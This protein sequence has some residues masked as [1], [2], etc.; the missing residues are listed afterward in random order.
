MR[1][2]SQFWIDPWGKIH[3]WKG[4]KKDLES[5][6]SIRYAIARE[7]VANKC[8]RY[9]D[10]VLMERG[11]IKFNVV[12]S[13]HVIHREPTVLQMKTLHKLKASSIKITYNNETTTQ[14]IKSPQSSI[15][16]S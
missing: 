13:G 5:L 14:W 2:K 7:I 16:L 4:K 3:K 10:D 8:L 11:W 15:F 6:V 12:G 9:P 1:H